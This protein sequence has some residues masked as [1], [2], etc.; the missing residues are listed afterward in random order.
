MRFLPTSAMQTLRS[1]CLSGECDDLQRAYDPDY[2]ASTIAV[3][4]QCRSAWVVAALVR[5][6]QVGRGGQRRFR[7]PERWGTARLTPPP[8]L[9]NPNAASGNVW[10]LWC[11][12]HTHTTW[13]TIP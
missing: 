7:P 2:W 6:S 12:V 10:S 11:G 8:P 1:A 5:P 4:E 3:L 13:G 9:G